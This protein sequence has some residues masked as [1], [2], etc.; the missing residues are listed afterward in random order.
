MID[1]IKDFLLEKYGEKK[2]NL[3]SYWLD[4]PLEKLYN[5]LK[6]F[7]CDYYGAFDDLDFLHDVIKWKE[8]EK[9]D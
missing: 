6:Y 9:G 5:R 4:M 1:S 2:Y 3:N 8:K 7:T